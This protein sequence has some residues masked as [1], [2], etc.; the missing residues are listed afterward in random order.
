MGRFSDREE[1]VEH[2]CQ[3]LKERYAINFSAA[4][5]IMLCQEL[6]NKNRYGH[7]PL[8]KDTSHRTLWLMKIR[9][10]TVLAVHDRAEGCFV[11]AL[12]LTNLDNPVELMPTRI[13][14]RG[15]LFALMQ[16]YE[17]ERMVD[18]EYTE[19]KTKA[20]AFEYFHT[21][22]TYPKIL[23]AMYLKQNKI[24]AIWRQVAMNMGMR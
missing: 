15:I 12:P 7:E 3:R 17:V 10:K 6:K 19:L 18:L 20:K 2:F 11:T 5:E 1:K 24:A 16:Y 4:D 23:E 22:T 9:R 14:K 8:V 21:K 13:R